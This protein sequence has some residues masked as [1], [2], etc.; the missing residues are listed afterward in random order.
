MREALVRLIW[1]VPTAFLAGF[2]Y[3]AIRSGDHLEGWV[4]HGVQQFV[5][6]TLGMCGLGL[7]ILWMSRHL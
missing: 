3:A 4:R 6:I 2:I 1:L 5:Y 7:V